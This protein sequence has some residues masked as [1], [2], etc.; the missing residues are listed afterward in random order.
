[1]ISGSNNKSPAS[2]TGIGRNRLLAACLLVSFVC[3]SAD[4]LAAA[5]DQCTAM[6]RHRQRTDEIIVLE[7]GRVFGDD[8]YTYASARRNSTSLELLPVGPALFSVSATRFLEH[9]WR[10]EF[11]ADGVARQLIALIDGLWLEYCLHSAGFSLAAAKTDCYQF[12]RGHGVTV[13]A[14][15]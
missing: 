8:A 11:D 2:P 9:R 3:C 6:D 14:D 13:N 7:E 5:I 12:L 15:Y 10:I 1:M 4:A